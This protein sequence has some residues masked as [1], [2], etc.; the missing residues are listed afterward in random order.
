MYKNDLVKI[1]QILDLPFSGKC[2]ESL[3]GTIVS[4]YIND[5]HDRGNVI[6]NINKKNKKRHLVGQQ[7]I[8]IKSKQSKKT[9]ASYRVSQPTPLKSTSHMLPPAISRPMFNPFINPW[10]SPIGHPRCPILPL[11]STQINHGI[12]A[13]T[14]PCSQ[15]LFIDNG[16]LKGFLSVIS[17]GKSFGCCLY[18]IVYPSKLTN[19]ST[20]LLLQ[21]PT[22][23][24]QTVTGCFS[25]GSKLVY[26]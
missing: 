14:L 22:L 26:F 6:H 3:C 20:L 24:C 10:T 16:S 7:E 2:K 11:P 4:H 23:V 25:I 8:A 1:A 12:H 17:K 21:I 19:N 18:N 5:E 13:V 9:H 15:G